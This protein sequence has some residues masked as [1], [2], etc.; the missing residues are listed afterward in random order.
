[1]NQKILKFYHS[2]F[3]FSLQEKRNNTIHKRSG[4]GKPSCTVKKKI[5]KTKLPSKKN[6]P[7]NFS[8]KLAANNQKIHKALIQIHHWNAEKY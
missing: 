6:I 7:Q 5:N 1:M 4:T 8:F 2:K 3:L